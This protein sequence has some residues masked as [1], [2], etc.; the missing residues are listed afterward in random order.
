MTLP[1]DQTIV[2]LRSSF[3]ESLGT[4]GGLHFENGAWTREE[5]DAAHVLIPKYAG[6]EWTKQT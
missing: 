1:F 5:L 3:V 2:Q 6:D 4:L